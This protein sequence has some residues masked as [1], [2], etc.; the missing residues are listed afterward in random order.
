M[1][2]G[3]SPPLGWSRKLTAGDTVR[4]S[5]VTTNC[6][7][8]KKLDWNPISSSLD[9]EFSNTIG[10]LGPQGFS[11]NPVPARTSMNVLLWVSV[12]VQCSLSGHG[13]GTLPS[14]QKRP[15]SHL[16]YKRDTMYFGHSH[17]HVVSARDHSNSFSAVCTS[18][19]AHCVKARRQPLGIFL[20]HYPL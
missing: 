3:S 20:R 19:W 16:C 18:V 10:S 17:C 12:V 9:H 7:S 14:A 5:A 4:D 8:R 15:I 13:K 2:W 6:Q 1:G 11:L